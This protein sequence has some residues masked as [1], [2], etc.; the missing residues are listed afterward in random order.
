MSLA[1]SAGG[2]HLPEKAV[3]YS[4]VIIQDGPT[5]RTLHPALPSHAA[6]EAVAVF[7]RLRNGSSR[8]ARAMPVDLSRLFCNADCESQ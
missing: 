5:Q 3:R 2:C 6:E 8:F 4:C 1:K 7:N